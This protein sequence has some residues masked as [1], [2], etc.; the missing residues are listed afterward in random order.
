MH[1]K[2]NPKNMRQGLYQIGAAP[3][4]YYTEQY[5][6][7]TKLAMLVLDSKHLYGAGGAVIP[8]VAWMAETAGYIFD[9]YWAEFDEPRFN[10]RIYF[11]CRVEEQFLLVNNYFDA[12]WIALGP[13][14]REILQP[15]DTV[16]K[17]LCFDNHLELYRALIKRWKIKITTAIVL[18]R[19]HELDQTQDA[20]LNPGFTPSGHLG[21]RDQ[22]IPASEIA[23]LDYPI[24]YGN[25]SNP[26]SRKIVCGAG[27]K[28]GFFGRFH[29]YLWPDVYFNRYLGLMDDDN[30]AESAGAFGLKDI[31]LLHVRL[32]PAALAGIKSETV[33]AT[34]STDR[35]WDLTF[36]VYK[37]WSKKVN[38]LIYGIHQAH[39]TMPGWLGWMIRARYLAVY[40]PNWIVYLPQ[41]AKLA[42]RLGNQR[43]AVGAD[44]FVH[45]MWFYMQALGA[46]RLDYPGANGIPSIK[47]GIIFKYAKPDKSPWE[48]EYSD[49]ELYDFMQKRKIAVAYTFG[50]TELSYGE[51]M[52]LFFDFIHS[53]RGRIGL[54][55]YLP[56]IEYY[57]DWIHKL[58]TPYYGKYIEPMMH[59][60]GLSAFF[61]SDNIIPPFTVKDFAAEMKTGAGEWQKRMGRDFL[62]IG[63]LGAQ[64]ELRLWNDP[65]RK[66]QDWYG[67]VKFKIAG[68]NKWLDCMDFCDRQAIKQYH[69]DYRERLKQKARAVRQLGYQYYMGEGTTWTE[70]EFVHVACRGYHALWDA[71]EKQAF[72]KQRPGYFAVKHDLGITYTP[73]ALV[74]RNAVPS[75]RSGGNY[76]AM[77]QIKTLRYIHDGG[78]AGNLFPAK[79][80]ELVRY[81]RLLQAH[82]WREDGESG[83]FSR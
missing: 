42:R 6:R 16:A 77:E 67:D 71:L 50:T 33:D 27:R 35:A 79:S 51:G 55:L 29:L 62:P 32:E 11:G 76:S 40:D 54:G 37:R 13:R 1:S 69:G 34:S 19:V 14:A 63:Y 60:W 70:G 23:E 49:D 56:W 39:M 82:G 21:S 75:K 22:S 59:Y 15:I 48:M 7:N 9:C 65:Y 30:P 72:D 2:S 53:V 78:K 38:G 26:G 5:P 74:W 41:A 47:R 68:T 36:R 10:K 80:N 25:Q 3:W 24:L 31:R 61:P 20:N 28:P 8:S 12:L 64:R 73:G 43:L 45:I 17:T 44:E 58:W 46:G 52:P 66:P 57:S 4:K 83:Q 81:I 18:P